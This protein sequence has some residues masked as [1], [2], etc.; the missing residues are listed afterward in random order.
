MRALCFQVATDREFPVTA[1]VQEPRIR[2]TLG[3][4]ESGRLL[5]NFPDA[6]FWLEI[7]PG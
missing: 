1:E 7:T 4:S 3:Q 2:M 5:R 6:D